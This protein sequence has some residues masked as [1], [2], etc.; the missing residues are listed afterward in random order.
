MDQL[1]HD[2]LS[3]SR[4][5]EFLHD[6]LEPFEDPVHEIQSGIEFALSGANGGGGFIALAREGDSLLGALVMIPTGMEGYVPPNLLLYVAVR[7][8]MRGRGVGGGLITRSLE[9]CQGAVKLHVEY[10]NPARRLYER[11]GFSS[12]YAE[13]RRP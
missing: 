1:S 6:S 10:D 2:D 3:A 9:R 12:A 7:R 8:D 13:M 4:L 5:A 11:L